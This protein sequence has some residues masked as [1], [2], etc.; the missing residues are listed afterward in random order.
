MSC[1]TTVKPCRRYSP[2]TRAVRRG[3]ELTLSER[4]RAQGRVI[5]TQP[6]TII[7]LNMSPRRWADRG[8]LWTKRSPA[9]RLADSHDTREHHRQGHLASTL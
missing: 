5:G 4:L 9:R 3:R 7:F 1:S 8:K 2:A 6:T